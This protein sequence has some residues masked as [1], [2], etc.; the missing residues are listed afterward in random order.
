MYMKNI[1]KSYLN[2]GVPRFQMDPWSPHVPVDYKQPDGRAEAGGRGQSVFDASGGGHAAI[3][4]ELNP[5]M[6]GQPSAG[7]AGSDATGHGPSASEQ[8]EP[9]PDTAFPK[10]CPQIYVNYVNI[11]YLLILQSKNNFKIPILTNVRAGP[12]N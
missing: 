9:L 5:V 11:Q 12:C 1:V 2:S 3:L 6:A 10:S 7:P 8:L 4:P